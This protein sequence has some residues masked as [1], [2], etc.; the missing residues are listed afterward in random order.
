MDCSMR[1]FPVL[2]YP[3]DFAQ[4]HVHWVGDAIQLSHPLPFSSPFA[5]NLSQYQSFFQ[6]VFGT[7]VFAIQ[8]VFG[9]QCIC[10]TIPKHCQSNTS[11]PWCEELTHW[12]RPWCW[13]RL[14]AGG[15]VDD[16]GW[17]DWMASMDMSLSK[18]RE[19]VKDRGS[20]VCCSP[21]GHKESDTTEQLNSNN[22]SVL[23]LL[24]GPL[25]HLYMTTG[26]PIALTIRTFVSKV[27]SPLFT[28][29]LGLS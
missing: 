21:W 1:G 20:Q 29:C 4:V 7:H 18:L 14:K 12:K 15:E 16:R 3:P 6:W 11:A 17:D 22:F 19:I 8:F 5:F 25:S 28:T 23:R 26:K 24:H 2:H 27:I 9:L 10:N 13:E